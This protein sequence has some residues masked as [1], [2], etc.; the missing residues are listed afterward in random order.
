MTSKAEEGDWNQSAVDSSN[1]V[2]SYKGEHCSSTAA[3]ADYDGV[4]AAG[5]Y[6]HREETTSLS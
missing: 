1:I 5:E 3:T 6:I 4:V 2:V